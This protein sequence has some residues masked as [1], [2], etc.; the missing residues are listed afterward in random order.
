[1]NLIRS[2]ENYEAPKLLN[3][4]PLISLEPHLQKIKSTNENQSLGNYELNFDSHNYKPPKR[5]D[6][7]KPATASN[8]S[9][10]NDNVLKLN[11]D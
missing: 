8:N 4:N 5:C 1:M 11:F 7:F 10:S 9:R 6:S 2:Y 3:S